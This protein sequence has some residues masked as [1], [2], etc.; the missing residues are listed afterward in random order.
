MF[1]EIIIILNSGISLFPVAQ[2]QEGELKLLTGTIIKK[3]SN[4]LD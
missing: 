3:Y 2:K 4:T 1:L